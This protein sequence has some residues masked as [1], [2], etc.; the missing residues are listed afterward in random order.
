[1]MSHSTVALV[2]VSALLSV[3]G[4]AHSAMPTS[5]CR[6]DRTGGFENRRGAVTLLIANSAEWCLFSPIACQ[7]L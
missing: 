7:L 4:T 3:L 1:M 5:E 6:S 2:L